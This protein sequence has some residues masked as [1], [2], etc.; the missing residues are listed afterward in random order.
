MGCLPLLMF[1]ASAAT[2]TGDTGD[3][4]GDTGDATADT[5]SPDTGSPDTGSPAGVPPEDTALDAA[6]ATDTAAPISD[7][8]APVDPSAV[9]TAS[10]LAGEAGGV[11]CS[12]TRRPGL[13]IALIALAA[14]SQRRRVS[15]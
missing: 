12:H 13:G 15:P 8:A 10:A 4:T 11:G 14:W 2:M 5:G 6:G 7:T 1:A 9:L 3:T